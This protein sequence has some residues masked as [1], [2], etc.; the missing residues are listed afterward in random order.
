MNILRIV[1]Y[2]NAAFANNF[3]LL[4][5]LGRMMLLMDDTDVSVPI[6]FKSNKSRRVTRSVLSA[7]F[8]TFADLFDDAF[9]IRHQLKQDY[10]AAY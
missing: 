9:A 2:S 7:E 1:G 10:A 4:S 6:S 8:I 5:Q 3:D